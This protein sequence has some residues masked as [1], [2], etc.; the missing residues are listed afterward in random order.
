MFLYLYRHRKRLDFEGAAFKSYLIKTATHIAQDHVRR[1][2][3]M[4]VPTDE[5]WDAT[6]SERSAEEL[7]IANMEG[8]ALLQAIRSLGEPD[9]TILYTRLST[10]DHTLSI[11]LPIRA[12]DLA[13]IRSVKLIP[14]LVYV[15]E[16]IPYI[17]ADGCTE[18][19]LTRLIVDAGPIE[20]SPHD[21]RIVIKETTVFENCAI[22]ILSRD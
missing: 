4:P 3:R 15:T 19:E 5:L 9:A 10:T 12:E 22:D 21:F 7:A 11:E 13:N 8:E 1:S 20:N 6:K 18:G 16:L 2:K 17:G 14:K